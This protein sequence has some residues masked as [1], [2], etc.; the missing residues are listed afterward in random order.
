[1]IITHFLHL[2]IGNYVAIFVILMVRSFFETYKTN[3]DYLRGFL[4]S[5]LKTNLQKV[6]LQILNQNYFVPR[7][8]QLFD[9]IF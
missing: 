7:A 5:S 6:I 9:R 4:Y 2:V 8:E 3:H 1:V